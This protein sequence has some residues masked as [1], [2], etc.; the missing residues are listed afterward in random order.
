MSERKD[1]ANSE[2]AAGDSAAPSSKNQIVTIESPPLAPEID[3]V[4]TESAKTEM[5]TPLPDIDI[6]DEKKVS[7]SAIVRRLRRHAPLAAAIVLAV[8]IG[9]VAGAYATGGFAPAPVK[10]PTANIAESQTLQ[11]TIAR[12]N[13]EVAALKSNIESARREA[14]S[15]IAKITD[16]FERNAPSAG[17]ITASITPPARPAPV[18]P[19]ELT[20]SPPIVPGWFVR[21]G[22]NGV[23]LVEGGGETYEVV[24]GAPLPGLGR[25]EAIRREGGRW[26]VVTP[27]G[28]IT[29][30]R[31]PQ[32]Y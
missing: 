16:R 32:P 19:N 29:S 23:V 18:P 4:K 25:V 11:K 9:A 7:N 30:M 14:S 20:K 26:I 15:Q 10:Q 3:R 28:I 8:G 24:P 5:F 1:E 22:G 21:N 2:K 17:D 13:G 31:G 6:I 27:K 12:L